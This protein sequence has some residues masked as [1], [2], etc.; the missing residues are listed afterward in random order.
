MGLFWDL[1]QQGQINEQ[2]HKSESLE[3]RVTTLE[4][5][6][7]NTQELLFKTL[8]VLEEY[9]NQDINGDGKIGE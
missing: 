4:E 5:E 9:T 8:K 2:H 7:K 3:Q 6:L 1:I